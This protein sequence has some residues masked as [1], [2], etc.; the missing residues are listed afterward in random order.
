[1]IAYTH[2][3][4]IIVLTYFTIMRYSIDNAKIGEYNE[5]DSR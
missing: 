4:K 3:F 5:N 1:M 2:I